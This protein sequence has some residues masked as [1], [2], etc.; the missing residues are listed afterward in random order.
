MPLCLQNSWPS[1]G[2]YIY[3][4]SLPSRTFPAV[5]RQIQLC[6]VRFVFKIPGPRVFGKYISSRHSINIFALSS[7]LAF[8][9]YIWFIS[10]F[11]FSLF[12]QNFWA[13]IQKTFTCLFGDENEQYF[14]AN[15]SVAIHFH[16]AFR[17]NSQ[18]DLSLICD[19]SEMNELRFF[20]SEL[21]L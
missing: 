11:I 13:A 12:V 21:V 9:A 19:W 6:L 18:S 1:F 10:I 3:V 8:E 2:K 16:V 7:S 20:C 17:I 15:R 14:V 5:I 4:Y